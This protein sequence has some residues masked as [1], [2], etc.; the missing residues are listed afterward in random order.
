MYL[1]DTSKLKI[2]Q[3]DLPNKLGMLKDIT[4][5]WVNKIVN[6]VPLRILL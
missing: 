1:S 2:W 3:Q 4:S 6:D 5:E